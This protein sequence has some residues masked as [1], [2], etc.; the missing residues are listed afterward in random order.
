MDVDDRQVAVP[1]KALLD[2][3]DLS[4]RALEQLDALQ[5][6]DALNHALRGALM[7]VRI[8]TRALV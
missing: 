4:M 6:N 1:E 5:P 3:I 2:V 7:D 8:Q